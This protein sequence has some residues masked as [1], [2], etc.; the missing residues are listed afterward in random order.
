MKYTEKSLRDYV[1][2]CFKDAFN[3]E[4]REYNRNLYDFEWIMIKNPKGIY[5]FY[6]ISSWCKYERIFRR[7]V[8]RIKNNIMKNFGIQ[9]GNT[10]EL[11][12]MLHPGGVI[13]P[14]HTQA[15][16]RT[17]RE[18]VSLSIIGQDELLGTP[19]KKGECLP[20]YVYEKLLFTY[21]GVDADDYRALREDGE[22]PSLPYYQG[23]NWEQFRDLYNRT[24]VVP[25]GSY[26]FIYSSG[27]ERL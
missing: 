17:K 22:D 24:F 9:Y 26:D 27:I 23:E 7:A 6:P 25:I 1:E 16:F 4:D 10:D 19:E 5:Q 12:C 11:Y 8:N 2:K 21:L 14:N 15:M 3:A 18:Y 20:A 13:D